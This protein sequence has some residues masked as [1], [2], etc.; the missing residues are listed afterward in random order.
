MTNRFY[1]FEIYISISI[2]IQKFRDG[3]K[4]IMWYV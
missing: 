1:Y 4:S 2:S 3:I